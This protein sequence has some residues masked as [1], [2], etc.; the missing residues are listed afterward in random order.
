[1]KSNPGGQLPVDE[2]LGR[3][4][5][6]SNLW[7]ILDRTSVV[8]T[9]ERRI[10]KTSII[11]KMAAKPAAGWVPVLQDLER[12]HS[13]DEFA[14]AVYKEVHQFLS[15]WK[16]AANSATKLWEEIGGLEI[17]GV[18]KL[19]ENQQKHWKTL[20][21]RSVEDLGT[22]KNPKRLLFFWDEMPYMLDSIRRRNGEETAMEVLDVLRALR[23]SAG[24][25]RMVLTGSI[26]LHHVLATLREADYRNEP[27]NDMYQV[28]VTPLAQPDAEDLARRLIQGEDL[29]TSD[30]ETAAKTIAVEGDCFPFY[31]HSI[32]KT[33]RISGR[34][35]EQTQIVEA[36]MTQ[37]THANDPWELAHYRTRIKSYYPKDDR[38]ITT[39]L[40]F[41][42]ACDS[43]VPVDAIFNA[44]KS[45][46]TF[47]DRER[48]LD[49][50]KLLQRDHYLAR[51]LDGRYH[52][53]FPL[54]QRWWKLDRGL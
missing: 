31:I 53:R 42:A 48:L 12:I 20:L 54:I 8:M 2:I 21:M 11:R 22:Q 6:I 13:A 26:G 50:L 49:V 38:V 14:V 44:V 10:G 7:D 15:R 46:E 18:L 33:L 30:M 27:L 23:Q 39:I 40:D 25:F 3:D 51:S 41:L 32:V 37:L 17:G 19:P 9:A 24:E 16:R 1:M 45:S 28:E 4:L 47:D 5:L 34:A 52:F 35:A 36:V 43:P 29:T